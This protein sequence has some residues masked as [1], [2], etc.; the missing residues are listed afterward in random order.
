MRIQ[1]ENKII[2]AFQ[3][4]ISEIALISRMNGDEISPFYSKVL[5]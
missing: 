1:R 4:Q 2:V 5:R 3:S